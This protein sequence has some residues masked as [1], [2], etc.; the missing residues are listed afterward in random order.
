MSGALL[1]FGLLKAAVVVEVAMIMVAAVI[2]YMPIM[3]NVNK[4]KPWE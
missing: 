4:I 1:R 2:P 3:R